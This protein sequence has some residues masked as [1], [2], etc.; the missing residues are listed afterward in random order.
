MAEVI[1]EIHVVGAKPHPFRDIYHLLRKM[2]WTHAMLVCVAFFAVTNALFALGYMSTGGVTGAHPGSFRDAFFFS[3]QTMG[4]IGYGA[5]YP[6]GT[7]ASLLVFAETLM[8]IFFSALVTGM[9]F[10][11]F[12]QPNGTLIFSDK[13][14]I[15][16]HDG[17][18]TL[19]FRIGNDRSTTVY[20]AHI[21]VVM[22]RTVKTKEGNTFYK[23]ED[24]KLVRDC[25]PALS[26]SWN[27]LHAIDEN[28]PLFR[29]TPESCEVEEFEFLVSVV[30]T[31]DTSLQP[32]HAR[33]RYLLSDVVWGARP[34]D[35]LRE[36]EPNVF[37]LDLRKFHLT[38]PTV[39]TKDFP[40]P[41][42]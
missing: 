11:R 25:A 36:R 28:S 7:G 39:A 27:V 30:G 26:R 21:R 37:E 23:A 8:G 13:L 38:V 35:V 2:P 40:F 4:T 29:A 24:V 15:S 34:A 32:V 6:E 1:E 16:P 31:D 33:K 19:M 41:R 3:V 10:A 12:S 9:V 17:V 20:E 14:T 42:A 18:P 22:Y 5:M